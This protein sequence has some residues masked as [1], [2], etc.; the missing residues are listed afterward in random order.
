[1]TIT[2]IILKSL[3]IVNYYCSKLKII[4]TKKAV[5]SFWNH[6]NFVAQIYINNKN[7]L[8]WKRGFNYDHLRT[9]GAQTSN[10]F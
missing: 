2:I 5:F 7:C 9:V 6:K 10:I 4:N 1:M 8:K 3:I